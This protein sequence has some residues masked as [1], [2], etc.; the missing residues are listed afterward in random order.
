MNK[1]ITKWL[2]IAV[3][4]ISWLVIFWINFSVVMPPI[5]HFFAIP[6]LLITTALGAGS[7]LENSENRPASD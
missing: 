3:W 4:L 7:V 1:A 6:L 2:N 5:L